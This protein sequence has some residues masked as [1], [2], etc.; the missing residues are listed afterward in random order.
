[1]SKDVS[2]A[3]DTKGGEEI[4]Q[5]MMMPTVK[6]KADAIAARAASMAGSMSKEP[7]TISVTTK[8]GTIKRGVRAIATISAEG[9]NAHQN[10]VGHYVLARAKDAGR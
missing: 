7:P 4:L 10:Y 9:R 1:M 3:M 6:A 8:I 5:S 2:F